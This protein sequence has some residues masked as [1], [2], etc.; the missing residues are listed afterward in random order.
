MQPSGFHL[1]KMKSCC[2]S[3]AST[4]RK[5]LLGIQAVGPAKW[6]GSGTMSEK[7]QYSRIQSQTPMYTRQSPLSTTAEELIQ[8]LCCL[9]WTLSTRHSGSWYMQKKTI[10]C[11]RI[12]TAESILTLSV[13]AQQSLLSFSIEF[14]NFS[15]WPYTVH[16][17]LGKGRK[18]KAICSLHN[19]KPQLC[20]AIFS[21]HEVFLGMGVEGQVANS[22]PQFCIRL[23]EGWN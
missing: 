8:W 21:S 5:Q 10:G 17:M 14:A 1:K 20:T 16:L 9:G 13:P 12:N 7:K 2:S 23:L 3:T 18:N 11:K 22:I 19:D 4:S 15:T 6:R